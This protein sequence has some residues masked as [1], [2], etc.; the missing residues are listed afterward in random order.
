MVNGVLGYDW[1]NRRAGSSAVGNEQLIE[2][3]KRGDEKC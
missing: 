3:K 1:R 2:G